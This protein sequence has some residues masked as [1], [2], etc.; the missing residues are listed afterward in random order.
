M[1]CH[2]D[3]Y[4][5]SII[6]ICADFPQKVYKLSNPRS[7]D[8]EFRILMDTFVKISKTNNWETHLNENRNAPPEIISTYYKNDS[9][10]YFQEQFVLGVAPL[11]IHD[12]CIYNF[13]TPFTNC[14]KKHWNESFYNRLELFLH[15]YF[16]VLFKNCFLKILKM[17]LCQMLWIIFVKIQ[18]DKIFQS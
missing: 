3:K 13:I 8:S 4:L 16:H 14:S 12:F 1:K 18:M 10:R 15:S 6:I 11:C 5:Y 2:W 17:Y 7:C 9:S